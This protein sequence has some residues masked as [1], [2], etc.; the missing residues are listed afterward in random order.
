MKQL[1]E[2]MSLSIRARYPLLY[3]VTSEEARAEE[4]LQE[5]AQSSRKDLFTW[6][7]SQGLVPS[8]DGGPDC[9]EPESILKHIEASD[10]K[11]I[12]VLRDF[13]P[14][15][16]KEIV[17]RRLRDLISNLKK[18][19]KTVVLVSP[20][21]KIP[22]ELEK[23]I[24]VF[25]LPLPDPKELT[26][27]LNRLLAPYRDSDK[28]KIDLPPELLEKVVQAT[29]GL[30]RNEAENVFAKALIT[31][32]QFGWDDLPSI[33]EEKKQL[34]RKSGILDFI[35]LS[36][37]L[38][39]VGG[40]D[41]LKGWLAERGRAFSVKA[42]DYGLPEPKGLLMLGVQGCGKSLA[43]KAIAAE[44]NLPL[45][46]LDVGKIFDSFVG[47][48]E[49]NMRKAI[50]QAEAMSPTILW[51]DEIEK[52]FSG[53]QSS[54]SVDSGTTARIFATF[55]TWMQE[56]TK[57]V[58]VIATANNVEDLPPEL[59]RKGRFDEIF[60]IDLPKEGERAKI[61]DI[62][63]RLKKRDPKKFDVAA[64]AKAADQFSGA[65]IEQ[66]ILS[67]MYRAYAEDRE[68]TTEDVA[69]EIGR[70]VP[71]A[72]TMKEKVQYLRDWAKHRAR[73]A[74]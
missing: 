5:I 27:V 15:L 42:R 37:Q 52:G 33:I 55:L 68:F 48:S 72:V 47:S 14:F 63:I 20:V 21:M 26:A 56:K 10:K 11:A 45:L 9:N 64:L 60:F 62:H 13:H 3:L 69:Q 17:L 66:A 70:T 71:L 24:T 35:G 30:T 4:I 59:L 8:K 54:G 19:Y 43:A 25:D 74:S 38:N 23:D 1:K 73:P 39:Q 53:I 46:R 50:H 44:W 51:L 2:D 36:T 57:P 7:L 31:G 58:F 67:A 18:S 32:R 65:E 34:I 41:K 49:D 40:L 28:V 12:F 29:L 22:P 61:F 16:E 6:S